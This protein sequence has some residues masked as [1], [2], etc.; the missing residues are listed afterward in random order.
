VNLGV[1]AVPIITLDADD[2]LIPTSM[3]YLWYWIAVAYFGFTQDQ[4]FD[5]NK[6]S[7]LNPFVNQTL[8]NR[9]ST[10]LN[11]VAM[12]YIFRRRKPITELPITVC[13][14]IYLFTKAA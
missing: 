2:H 13:E 7:S 6:N 5:S 3:F 9:Y 11:D 4:C 14:D 10:F 8:L 1:G 12:P